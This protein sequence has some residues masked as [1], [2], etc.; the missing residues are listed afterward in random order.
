MA[1]DGKVKVGVELDD[2]KAAAEAAKLGKNVGDKMQS[3][4]KDGTEKSGG[5]LEKLKGKFSVAFAAIGGIVAGFSLAQMANQIVNIGKQFEESMSKVAA[6]SGATG[7]DFARLEAKARELGA[8]TTFSASEAADALGY[9]ALAGWDTEEMLNGVG[10]V[11][12]LAQAGMMDLGQASDLVTDY[13]SAFNMSADET[14]RMVDVLAY[15]QANA[16]T[17]VEG[18]GNAFKL[19]AANANAAGMDIETTSAAISMM[20]NQGLKG[21]QAGTALSAVMRDMTAKMEDGY[22]AIGDVNVAVQD[23]Q[24]NY[25]DFAAILGDVESA[26]DGMGSAERAASLMTTFTADSIRGLNLLLNAGSDELV[27]FRDELYN[28]EGAGQALAD[29]MTDNLEG[30][31]KA[32]NS[33][34]EELQLKVYESLKEPLRDGTQF[35]TGTVIPAVTTLVQNFDKIGPVLATLGVALVAYRKNWDI[36]TAAQNLA[37]KATTA[38]GTAF[39][40]FIQIDGSGAIM[41]WD[42]ATQSY[43]KTNSKFAAGLASTTAG[44]KAQTVAQNVATKATEL[45]GKAAE[46]AGKA[47]RTMA[48]IAVLSVL[49]NIA[50]GFRKTAEDAKTLEKATT[51]LTKAHESYAESVSAASGATEDYASSMSDVIA[52]NRKTIEAQAELADSISDTWSETGGSVGLVEKYTATIERLTNKYDENGKKVAL[53]AQ[54]QAELQTAVAGINKETESNYQILDLVNGELDTGTA[55]IKRNSDAWIR[56]ARAQAAQS[57]LQDIY[58]QQL[59]V[60]RQLDE[61]NKQLEESEKGVGLYVGD[62]AVFADEAAVNTHELESQR[63]ALEESDKALAESEEYYLGIISDTNEATQESAET[64]GEAAAAYSEHAEALGEAADAAEELREADEKAVKKVGEA[65]E[66]YDALNRAFIESSYTLDEF[67]LALQDAGITAD[68]LGQAMQNLSDKTSDAFNEI[69]DASEASL[70]DMIETLAKNRQATENWSSNIAALYER[71]GSESERNFI[72]YMASLGPE[73]GRQVQEL[74]DD[75]SGK[76]TV[77]ADEWA[78]G[79]E[80]GRDAAITATGVTK[81]AVLGELASAED[82]AYAIGEDIDTSAGKGITDNAQA[83]KNAAIKTAEN[84]VTEMAN[85]TKGK[86]PLLK[87][88]IVRG[89]KT[90]TDAADAAGKEGGAKAGTNAAKAEAS[91]MEAQK[92]TL[93]NAG[94]NVAQAGADGAASKNGEYDKAG[95]GSGKAYGSGVDSQKGNAR[96]KAGGV[97]QAAANEMGKH[98]NDAYSS[99]SFLGQGFIDGIGSKLGGAV[100]KAGELAR[101]AINEIKRVGQE[102]SPWKTTISSGEFAGEGLAVGL[103]RMKNLVK[104]R[105][106][107]LAQT[108]VDSIDAEGGGDGIAWDTTKKSGRAA[109]RGLVVGFE[110]FQPMQQIEASIEKGVSAMMVAASAGSMGNT[111]NNQTLNFNGPVNSPDE[112]AR[113][114]RMQ[115]RYGLAGR[116]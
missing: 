23:S 68:D 92:G 61:T 81:E 73:Y 115:Q 53:T 57:A 20:A 62:F 100:A 69:K 35:I 8:T 82:E 94:R 108:A 9:M 101:G 104:N 29:T 18:L 46:V 50:D 37:A 3:G 13:L 86:M 17:T 5:F 43:V 41:K 113:Q 10:G 31:L 12:T 76:L 67:T 107:K 58:K 97:A 48:P 112:I 79:M 80:A 55:A 60:K 33:A 106:G 77:L 45:G 42:K 25:R 93:S 14:S 102:G 15:A 19:C 40:K 34:L 105:A 78:A 111:T 89:T 54:E 7:D 88:A 64:A 49:M 87:D 24:G 38:N 99:G 32:L 98:N 16:N 47:M 114:M 11:L 70:D 95:Q 65:L 91:A 26:V 51:G 36:V 56:N 27:S 39:R 84:V 2:Q 109:A 63:T 83:A 52:A 21:Q 90:A 4:I 22:I 30:D 74:V 72:Q 6:L 103:E 96:S 85:A 59:D 116:R 1:D 110:D 75:T 71:A 66:K 44:I 28:C